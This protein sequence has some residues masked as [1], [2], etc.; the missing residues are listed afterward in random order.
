MET[1]Y[2]TGP[3]QAPASLTLP[4]KAYK[5]RAWIAMISLMLF[6]VVYFALA[7]WFSWTAY[8]VFS[9]M[10]A[11]GDVEFEKILVGGFAVFLAIFMLKAVIFIK[12]GGA[13][14]DV[15]V[16]AEQQPKLFEFLHKLADELGA[17]RP[18]RV[19]LS[20]R[21]NAAVFYDLS[22]LNLFFPSRKNLEI[23]LALVNVLTLSEMKAVLAHEFGHFAQRTMAIG[24]WVY[25]SQQI[26]E[27]LIARRDILDG[28]L[29]GLS[30]IDFRIAWIGWILSLIVWS[31]RSLMDSLLRLVILAQAALSRQMEFQADLVAVSVTGSDELV[32]A[33]HKLQAADEAW[34]SALS[35]A[36]TQ[37]QKGNLPHD[38][39][40]IQ[41]N[42][43]GK[44][45]R[46]L[47]DEHYGKIPP[48]KGNKP[49]ENRVFKKGFAQ[50]PQMWSSHPSNADREENNKKQ[51]L[52]APHDGRSAW[53]LF[54][55][56]DNLKNKV[57]M[58]LIGETKAKPI[59]AEET[60]KELDKDYDLLKYNPYYRGAYMGRPLTRHV[61][62]ASELY[63]ISMTDSTIQESLANL[64]NQKLAD[65]IVRLRDLE[66]EQAHLQA[67]LDKI[68]EA[69]GGRII[70]RG[71]QIKRRALPAA[72]LQVGKEV[73]EVRNLIH[74]HDRL[75]RSTH[76]AIASQLGNGWE[77]YMKGLI[78]LLHYAEHSFADLYDARGA[79]HNVVAV[80]TADG[81]VSSKEL[82]RLLKS[83]NELHSVLAK[84]NRKKSEIKPDINILTRLKVSKWDEKLE[85]FKLP[86]A[87]ENN[88]N[89]WMSSFDG[90]VG[91]TLEALSD[92]CSETLEQ[93]LQTEQELERLLK[94]G[95]SAES[96]PEPSK[97][98]PDYA[99]L[100]QGQERK[101][102]K[103]LGL[104]DRFQIAD[105]IFPGTVRLLIACTIVGVVL[106]FGGFTS[107][108]AT[109]SVYNGL[110]RS[111]NIS[112][113]DQKVS[114]AP[115]G[116]QDVEIKL[117]IPHVIT[118]TTDEG[119]TIESFQPR[120][121]KFAQHY[122]YNVAEASPIIMWVA[123]YGN[124]RE[125]PPVVLGV[126]NWMNSSAD[127]YFKAPP[128]SVK[129]KGGGAVRTVL[130][131]AGELKPE[132]ILELLKN[133]ADRKKLIKAHVQ[134][135]AENSAHYKQWQELAK[136]TE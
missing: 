44:V 18:C 100:L 133:K 78:K 40:A 14:D 102:Q 7:G 125:V 134:W 128:K 25:I 72:I 27:Q 87:S 121:E 70:H 119:K 114:L 35:F 50:P 111:V 130:S 30:R 61:N 84:I 58:N 34:E 105:G 109:V 73:K 112:F 46:I 33:L 106:G 81:N 129:I 75:C 123:P 38:L 17:P 15:E 124:A 9:E 132:E 69:T 47:G 110:A 136:K 62:Q 53:I 115:F 23:G 48:K 103:Q 57:M 116:T 95:K 28:F 80:V 79:L 56:V 92:L 120:M 131:G 19:Y 45:S 118:T 3:K 20:P 63:G 16:T 52:Q 21:V 107:S 126:T 51:Y 41:S 64:Y 65:D 89:D 31:I 108:M 8:R 1:F 29:K 83:A 6:V 10:M 122:V 26:A 82:K 54:D 37:I 68:F 55:K 135:D 117:N 67:L 13:P 104:W 60:L 4:S 91:L 96:A 49:D 101:R 85:E 32:H 86:P 99:T 36:S 12:R 113:D 59:S 42:I 88:I 98:L 11:G 127:V 5:Q 93:L 97:I 94:E 74:A 76:L 22:I 24:R 43:I 66:E 71:R 39:F 90:W 2:P 77:D